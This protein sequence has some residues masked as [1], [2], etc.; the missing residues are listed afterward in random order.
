MKIFTIYSRKKIR[1]QI[2][3]NLSPSRIIFL[4]FLTAILVGSGLLALP[5][6]SADGKAM[7][8]IDA[9]FTSTSATCVTGLIVRDTGRDFSLFGQLVVLFLV[10][11]GGLGIMTLSTAFLMV[12][13][14]RMSLRETMV[15][16]SSLGHNRQERLPDLIKHAVLLTVTFEFIGAAV[17]FVRMQSIGD[18][19]PAQALYLAV[20][21]SI[22][23]FCNAG[24]SLHADSLTGYNSDP[25]IVLTM[26]SLVV[27]GGLGFLVLYNIRGFKFWQKDRVERGRFTLQSKIV[28]AYS[29]VLLGA[30]LILFLF[31]EWNNS[32]GAMPMPTKLL[33]AFFCSVT[34]RTAGFNTVDY[35]GLSD[36]SVL[37]T[38]SLMVIGASPGSTGGGIK[39]STLAVLLA[40]SYAIVKG[41]TSPVLFKRTISLRIVSEAIGVVSLAVMLILVMAL[42]LSI[43]ENGNPEIADP[44]L[45]KVVFEVVSAF[46]TVGLSLGA[47]PHLSVLGK[48]IISITMFVGRLGPVA[49]AI[50]IARRDTE[51][52]SPVAYPEEHVM[53]G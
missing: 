40:T 25:L 4:S 2:T 26:S 46:G 32:M 37:L 48:L 52:Q 50:V 29:G 1:G 24:F 23:G 7:P 49:I 51:T 16:T 53:I 36:A 8:Y 42:A 30:G 15:M 27:C 38:M 20:F 35:S 34:A 21:H 12:L 3:R 9:L 45:P 33:N 17:L 39:T 47:T 5:Y 41:K 18:M 22:S 28:L 6:A 11:I 44:F 10:Q 13:G 19:M 14:R 31:F 43:V